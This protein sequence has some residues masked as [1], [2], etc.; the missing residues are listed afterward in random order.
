MIF[1]RYIL[2]FLLVF[3][4]SSCFEVIEKVHVK[5]DGSGDFT[6]IVNAS[7]SQAEINTIVETQS[8]HGKPIPT[9]GEIKAKVDEVVKNIQSI[10]GLGNVK[11]DLDFDHY[12]FKVS[13]NFKS[14][15]NIEQALNKLKSKK[16]LKENV[17]TRWYSYSPYTKMFTRNNFSSFQNDFKDL[18]PEEK[19]QIKAATYTVI[20]QFDD[21]IKYFNNKKYS[22]SAGK[23][24]LKQTSKVV[25]FLDNKVQAQLMVQLN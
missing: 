24:A 22:I 21:K 18:K 14:L 15:N 8:F 23:N 10:S 2:F 13:G 25:D 3:S 19:E 16:L 1:F 17:P 5:T 11:T 4:L 6:Y 12:I 9:K 20:F 7:K